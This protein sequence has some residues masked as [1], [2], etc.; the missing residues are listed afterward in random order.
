M[1][2]GLF[3]LF[4]LGENRFEWNETREKY[5][6]YYARTHRKEIYIMQEIGRVT[7]KIKLGGGLNLLAIAGAGAILVNTIIK[8]DNWVEKQQR[9]KT[10]EDCI[11][12]IKTINECCDKL[13][14]YKPEKSEENAEETEEAAE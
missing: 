1:V 10:L 11:N 4:E 6:V 12:A 3:F 5:I 2:R 8:I 9:A 14:K 13:D 7:T